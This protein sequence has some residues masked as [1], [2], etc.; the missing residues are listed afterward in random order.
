MGPGIKSTSSWMLIGLVSA[1]PWR[2]LQH[3]RVFKQKSGSVRCMLRLLMVAVAIGW[4]WSEGSEKG[5]VE[6]EGA[7]MWSRKGKG[8]MQPGRGQ[9]LWWALITTALVCLSYVKYLVSAFSRNV[10]SNQSVH[11][12]Q[13]IFLLYHL[14]LTRFFR[15]LLGDTNNIRCYI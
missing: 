2:E 15:R 9:K 13:V 14:K 3:L 7:T 1:E 4:E 6:T 11:C 10:C 8:Q 5:W 12:S